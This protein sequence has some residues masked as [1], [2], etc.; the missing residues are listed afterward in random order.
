M[1]ILGCFGGT[2]IKKSV[3]SQTSEN[4]SSRTSTR[5]IPSLPKAIQ[6]QFKNFISLLRLESFGVGNRKVSETPTQ[7]FLKKISEH[8]RVSLILDS[9]HSDQSA[10]VRQIIIENLK[11]ET[12]VECLQPHN[13]RILS[14]SEDSEF[15]AKVGKIGNRYGSSKKSE[16]GTDLPGVEAEKKI[17]VS[18]SI[19][20][21]LSALRLCI[22]H[23]SSQDLTWR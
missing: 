17:C 6:E 22:E 21:E 20:A 5:K 23:H 8:E 1:I 15:S 9:L 3:H 11:S 12:P 2:T 14:L 19:E 10:I 7:S 4:M 16:V 18:C 13:L